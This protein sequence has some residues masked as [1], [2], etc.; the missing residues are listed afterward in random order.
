VTLPDERS[1]RS[2]AAVLTPLWTV[3]A[4]LVAPTAA[5][6]GTILLTIWWA[7]F[8]V[9]WILA[10]RRGL[11]E[12]RQRA[13]LVGLTLAGNGLV[14]VGAWLAWPSFG[15]FHTGGVPLIHL[16]T[17][18]QGFQAFD[19]PL[20]AIATAGSV[21]AVRYRRDRRGALLALAAGCGVFLWTV[22][23]PWFARGL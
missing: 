7:A 5:T 14:V 23:G 21:G 1:T 13:V 6:N 15:P 16:P 17:I 2:L 10:R 11:S 20:I 18:E 12:R 8:P 19:A 22:L 4:L 3:F 9:G